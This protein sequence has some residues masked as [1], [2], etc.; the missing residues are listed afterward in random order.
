MPFIARV[1]CFTVGHAWKLTLHADG[2][3]A[4]LCRRCRALRIREPRLTPRP[5]A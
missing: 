4:Y 5:T 2:R 1:I 3:D